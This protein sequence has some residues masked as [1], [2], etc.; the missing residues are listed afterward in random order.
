MTKIQL[1][2]AMQSETTYGI[3]YRSEF[4]YRVA[5]KGLHNP[6]SPHR[7]TVWCNTGRPNPHPG[8]IRYTDF[9]AIGGDGAYLNPNNVATDD[10]I[11]VLTGAESTVIT[12][13]GTNTGTVAAGQ[14]YAQDVLHVGN[15]VTLVTPG[16][17]SKEYVLTAIPLRDPVLIPVSAS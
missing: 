15:T 5:G 9:G 16:G 10:E 13:N 12:N 17:D 14:V 2:P 8:E 4:M 1:R 6:S 3:L 7:I 11:T